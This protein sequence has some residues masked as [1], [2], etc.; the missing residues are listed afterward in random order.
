MRVVRFAPIVLLLACGGADP[1][2]ADSPADEMGGAKES[3]SSSTDTSSSSAPAS[4][5]ASSSPADAPAPTSTKAADAPAAA[6]AAAAVH[7]A[8]AVTGAI[9]GKPFNPKTARVA[10]PIQKDGRILLTLVE[11]TDCAASGGPTLSMMVPWQDG[12]KQDFGSLKRAT[13]KGPGDISFARTGKNYVASFKPSGTVT[14]V[15][16]PMAQ[17]AT[18]KMKI[19]LQSGDYML[20]GD[21]DIQVC[22]APK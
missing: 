6:P 14:I 15:S 2:P 12:Y 8:P 3:S 19:D 1:K 21:L 7:P 20:A 10:G 16:A 17:N 5:A 9:D 18:G 13:K 11:A 22:V 4:A